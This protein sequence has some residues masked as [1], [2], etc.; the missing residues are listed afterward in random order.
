MDGTIKIFDLGSGQTADMGR[1][2]ASISSLSYVPGQNILVSSG[3]E[4]IINFW[5]AGN[6]NPVL[7]V[8]ADNKVYAADFQYPMLIAGTAN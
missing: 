5:Q 4:N 6:P 1:Q 2:T 3:Y 7:T 8:N